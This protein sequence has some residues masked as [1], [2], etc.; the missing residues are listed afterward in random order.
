MCR[1]LASKQGGEWAP[2]P[3]CPF[4]APAGAAR[5]DGVGVT[6]P[7][8]MGEWERNRAWERL[9]GSGLGT[10]LARLT[11]QQ[12]TPLTDVLGYRLVSADR[13]FKL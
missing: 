7:P 4:E 8:A 11:S 1:G 13:M 10:P 3:C 2:G 5:Q 9:G 6:G 12:V